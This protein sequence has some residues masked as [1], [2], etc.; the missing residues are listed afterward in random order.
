MP[1]A[2]ATRGLD[3]AGS[4]A[5]AGRSCRLLSSDTPARCRQHARLASSEC[6]RSGF[7]SRT[8]C[9]AERPATAPRTDLT[10]P[11]SRPVG[12]T[13]GDQIRELGRRVLLGSLGRPLTVYPEAG[14]KETGAVMRAT[15]SPS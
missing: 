8:E 15:L 12:Q 11:S 5:G 4:H 14:P 7:A 9:F 6:T 1:R 10:L 3:T 2:N 13:S